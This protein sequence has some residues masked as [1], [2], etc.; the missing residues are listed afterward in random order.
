MPSKVSVIVPTYN[1]ALNIRDCLQSV[2]LAGADEVILVDADSSDSTVAI[3]QEFPKTIILISPKG[4]AKQLNQGAASASGEYL[5]F[6]H[7]DSVVSPNSISLIK[8]IL[9][10]QE[11]ALG[12][13]SFALNSAKLWARIVEFGV[14][15]RCRVFN[16]PYGDQGFFIRAKTFQE[17][18]RFL[19]TEKI[20]DLEF[21]LRVR[22]EH[23]TIVLRE[24]L[25]TS[26]RKWEQRGVLRNTLRNLYLLFEFVLRKKNI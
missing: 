22:S 26:A 7:A 2:L 23:Q 21:W 17:V 19:E 12:A 11:I 10:R 13:F 3:G 8:D 14:N 6:L 9:L 16:L 20:E 25:L 18:G 1:E 15:L 5:W 4:R 24:K